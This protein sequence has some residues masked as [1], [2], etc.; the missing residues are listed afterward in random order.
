MSTRVLRGA[1]NKV[2]CTR[3]A[4]GHGMLLEYD[5]VHVYPRLL[6]PEWTGDAR[7]GGAAG[8]S[9]YLG[10]VAAAGGPCMAG[11]D[12]R[13]PSLRC[14]WLCPRGSPLRWCCGTMLV[15]LAMDPCVGYGHGSTLEG[16]LGRC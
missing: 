4:I 7:C 16:Q 5:L 14:I 6:L 2:E 13:V 9:P 3:L 11:Y 1:P 12:T 8:G 10:Q 15:A